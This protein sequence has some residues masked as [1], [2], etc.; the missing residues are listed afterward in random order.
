MS[1]KQ[2]VEILDREKALELFAES[3]PVRLTIRQKIWIVLLVA[4]PLMLTIFAVIKVSSLDIIPPV[5]YCNCAYTFLLWTAGFFEA[6][7][8]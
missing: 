7:R 5:F 6:I 2:N 4:Y 3:K 8:K 1:E